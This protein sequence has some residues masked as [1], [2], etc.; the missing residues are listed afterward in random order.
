MD[1]VSIPDEKLF[2]YSFY[3]AGTKIFSQGDSGTDIY[4]L[5]KG[6]VTVSVDDQL[7]GLINTPDTIIGEMAYFL[8]LKRTATVEAVE[9]SEFIVIPGDYLYDTI[10][11]KPEIGIQLLKIVVNRLANTT[12]YVS[13]LEQ[14][15]EELRDQLRKYEDTKEEPAKKSEDAEMEHELVDLGFI[16]AQQMAECI[17]EYRERKKTEPSVTILKILIEK[18]YLTTEQ[19]IQYLEL[20]QKQKS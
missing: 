8:G 2:K 14:E 7:V 9:D 1:R 11:K 10:L 3:R 15:I 19:I 18:G 20:K 4:I 12:K 6:A 16:S 13:R 5:K 17:Q